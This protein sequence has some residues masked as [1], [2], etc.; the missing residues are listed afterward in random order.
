MYRKLLFC[1]DVDLTNIKALIFHFA[2]PSKNFDD[3]KENECRAFCMRLRVDIHANNRCF[4]H[5]TV[6]IAPRIHPTRG[7]AVIPALTKANQF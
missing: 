6:A 7:S 1:D 5:C 4:I 3:E 2:F